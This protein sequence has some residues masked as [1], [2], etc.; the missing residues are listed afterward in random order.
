MC[1]PIGCYEIIVTSGAKDAEVSWFIGDADLSGGAPANCQ[2]NVGPPNPSCM[3]QC[4][5]DEDDEAVPKVRR[6]TTAE[7]LAGAVVVDTWSTTCTD[8]QIKEKDWEDKDL[9][10]YDWQE[11]DDFEECAF[12]DKADGWPDSCMALQ[13]D[14]ENSDDALVSGIATNLEQGSYFCSCVD[15]TVAITPNCRDYQD[16]LELLRE[17]GEACDALDAVDC[18][19]L[20]VFVSNCLTNLVNEFGV[21]DLS[22]PDQCVYVDDG[23]GGLPQPIFRNWDCLDPDQLTPAEA[24]FLAS[25]QQYCLEDDGDDKSDDGSGGGNDDMSDSN[26]TSVDDMTDISNDDSS[27]EK[28]SDSGSA[29][30]AAVGIVFAIL[31]VVGCVAGAMFYLKKRR[32][33]SEGY[34]LPDLGMA[35]FS[36]MTTDARTQQPGAAIA[37]ATPTDFRTLKAELET[38]PNRSSTAR[39]GGTGQQLATTGYIP[40]ELE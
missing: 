9:T 26:S 5:D 29:A 19:Y 38:P 2:F 27:S 30:G 33:N 4:F 8:P 14:A 17:S 25:Y 37:T 7:K 21:M 36:P 22:N 34:H 24:T 1:L 6:C 31:A 23:C 40:V 28:S 39:T 18:A 15:G 20:E 16:F 32:A 12:N 11:L 13:V 3:K 10:G 35:T